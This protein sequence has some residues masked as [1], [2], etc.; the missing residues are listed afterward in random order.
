MSKN[1]DILEND[2]FS[3]DP[4]LLSILLIDRSKSNSSTELRNIIWAPDN[5]TSK[6]SGYGEWDE[7]QVSAISGETDANGQTE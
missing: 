6:G 5:Y 1:S 2:L 4:Q 7:I 3:Y